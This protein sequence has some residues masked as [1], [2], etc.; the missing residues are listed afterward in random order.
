MSDD[1]FEHWVRDTAQDYNRPTDRVPREEMW[2]AIQAARHQAHVRALPPSG[3]RRR[4]AP[5]W[6]VAAAAVLLVGAGIGI[7]Y[8][9]RGANTSASVA[10]AD[11]AA[12]TGP[13]SA[14]ADVLTTYDVAAAQHL[15]SAEV[16]LTAFQASA[17]AESAN[18]AQRWARNLL[19]TTRLLLDSP[20]ATDPERRRLFED[21]ERILVQIVQLAPDAPPDDRAYV[22]RVIGRDQVLTRIRTSIPAGFAA[23]S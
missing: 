20:A 16:L 5:R 17:D 8:G 23:G 3:S 14:P 9:V 12:S 18:A 10:V 4:G 13:D 19:S 21:L 2:Q 6:R 7:G 22:E 11:T 15:T 1:T